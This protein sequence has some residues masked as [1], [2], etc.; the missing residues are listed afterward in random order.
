MKAQLELN[1]VRDIKENRKGFYECIYR[2]KK[3]KS[4]EG[5]WNVGLLLNETIENADDFLAGDMGQPECW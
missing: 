2:E 4:G 5:E 3:K 1:L